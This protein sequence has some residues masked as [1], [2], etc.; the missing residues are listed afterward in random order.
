MLKIEAFKFLAVKVRKVGNFLGI[1]PSPCESGS[2]VKGHG[3]IGKQGRAYGRKVMYM[4]GLSAK[5][6]NIYCKEFYK[7]LLK[8]GKSKKVALVAVAYKLLR[9]AFG[10]LK[11][12]VPFN[13]NLA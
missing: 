2:T 10:V 13:P 12:R 3:G 9:Q 5:R 8:K 4:C 1:C 11:N 7:R 6:V